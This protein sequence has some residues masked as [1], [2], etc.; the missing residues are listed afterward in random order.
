MSF[1]DLDSIQRRLC[2]IDQK[3]EWIWDRYDQGRGMYGDPKFGYNQALEDTLRL[4]REA[5]ELVGLLRK[6]GTNI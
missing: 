3:K 5:E 1:N 6:I 2:V 4:E